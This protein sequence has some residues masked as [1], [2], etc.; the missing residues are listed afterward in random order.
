MN[1]VRKRSKKNPLLRFVSLLVATILP[2]P[3]IVAVLLSVPNMYEETFLGALAPKVERIKSIDE[4]KIVVVGGSSVAFGLDSKMLSEHTGYEVVNFGLYA[5]LG[6]RIMLDLSREY[7]NQGDIVIIA[8]EL[9]KQTLSLYFNGEAM[10]QAADSDLSLLQKVH[11]DNYMD[12]AATLP[13]YLSTVL[14]RV[15]KGEGAI[16]PTGIYRKDS[17]NEYGD[18]IYPREY[19]IMTA[20]YD[21][22]QVLTLSKDIYDA[23]FV[24][25]LNEYI[26]DITNKGAKAYY[27]F[28]PLNQSA[29]APETTE[30]VISD[31]Y[32]HVAEM[33]ECPIISDPNSLILH[34]GYFYDTNFHLND[35]G[36]IIR[37]ANLIDDILRAEGRTDYVAIQIP[38]I[39]KRPESD[40]NETWE[41][42]KWSTMFYYEEFGDG[43]SIVGVKEEAKN[44][45]ALELPYMA[46]GK[47]VLV[48]SEEAFSECKNLKE[49]TIYEN[50]TLIENGAF[51][52]AN[53]L[54]YLHMRRET[55]EDLEVGADLFE[56]ASNNLRICFYSE[57]SFQNFVS[58]YWWGIHGE[59][60]IPFNDSSTSTQ[61]N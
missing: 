59:R 33:I 24:D 16:S 4:P 20:G 36:V 7:I 28:C 52:G 1:E 60:M 44:L 10:W 55:A 13:E 43:L 17:F 57:T 31:F 58:G 51:K 42:N 6:T 19:N 2:L 27:T 8:P 22:N 23:E 34:E 35:A 26:N 29:L 30:S 5:T 61:M 54:E 21:V 39:P 15:A 49:L 50:I 46:D 56:G 40:K 12:L 9:D 48:V 53:K 47:P 32:Q 41:E 37:T 38:E 45:E 3:V 25:Y 11:P 14:S 18:I